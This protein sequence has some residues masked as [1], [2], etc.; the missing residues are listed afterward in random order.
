MCAHVVC[1]QYAARAEAEY[2][3]ARAGAADPQQAVPFTAAGCDPPHTIYD[4]CGINRPFST[5]HD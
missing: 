1:L 4:A 2:E 3:D 5:M